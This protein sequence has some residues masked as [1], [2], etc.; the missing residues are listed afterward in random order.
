M[1]ELAQSHG[2][3][4]VA[5]TLAKQIR[6]AQVQY[7]ELVNGDPSDMLRAYDSLASMAKATD[8]DEEEE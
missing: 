5:K 4:S 2:E 8:E 1:L 7:G 6:L 3:Y